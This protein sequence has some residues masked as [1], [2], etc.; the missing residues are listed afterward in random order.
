MHACT[1]ALKCWLSSQKNLLRVENTT[2]PDSSASVSYSRWPWAEGVMVRSHHP[3][4]QMRSFWAQGNCPL[5]AFVEI[6]ARLCTVFFHM[7]LPLMR[8]SFHIEKVKKKNSRFSLDS[9]SP[10]KGKAT[11]PTANNLGILET[12]YSSCWTSREQPCRLCCPPIPSIH[13]NLSTCKSHVTLTATTNTIPRNVP[14]WEQKG[15][16]E[17]VN[18]QVLLMCACRV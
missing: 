12:L 15:S 10:R 4:R 1:H 5:L 8:M 7:L 14:K 18:I 11:E 6:S 2:S 9:T 13:P 16:G 17:F 3:S